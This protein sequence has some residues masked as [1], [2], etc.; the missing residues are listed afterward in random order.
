MKLKKQLVS[1]IY[2]LFHKEN[3]VNLEEFH[4]FFHI[5]SF[6]INVTSDKSLLDIFYYPNY[7]EH[8]NFLFT[9]TSS[10]KYSDSIRKIKLRYN[11]GA[12]N[13]TMDID[14]K[15]FL[16]NDIIYP[17]IDELTFELESEDTNLVTI[18]L[19]DSYDS[20]GTVCTK[21]FDS[22]PNVKKIILL[23]APSKS[24][25]SRNF[26]PIET[27]LVKSAFTNND[28]IKNLSQSS[29][30]SNLRELC[31]YDVDSYLIDNES[32]NTSYDAFSNLFNS[33]YL[34][35]LKVLNLINVNLDE[36]QI[37]ILKESSLAKQLEK[38]VVSTQKYNDLWESGKAKVERT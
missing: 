17:N 3:L 23:T 33:K 12:A 8:L 6:S 9:T 10:K 21:V 37:N 20:T 34:P 15:E 2:E 5:E 29:C 19:N 13:G 32:E 35:N 7:S 22:L 30:F 26:H 4:S 31:F 1:E 36:N 25:F 11:H 18:S 27:L 16:K 38:L 28:F 14:L 24:F